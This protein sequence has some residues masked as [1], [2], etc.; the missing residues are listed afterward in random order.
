VSPSIGIAVFPRDGITA[1]TLIKN[2]DAAMY[3]AKE[4]GRSN[5]QFFNEKLSEAAFQAL[6]LETGLREAIRDAGFVLHYQPAVRVRDQSLTGVA[7][8]IRWPRHDGTLAS[9]DEFNPVAE[10]RGLII[11]IGMWVLNEACRQNKAWQDAGLPRVP[12]GINLSALQFRQKSLVAEVAR[13]LAESGLEPKYLEIE[14]TESM[15][16]DD[17][18]AMT[19]TLEGLKAL[20]VKL[21]I[22]DFGTGHS[23][24]VHLKRFPLDKLKIDRDFVRDIPEDPDDVAITSAIID[25]ARNMGITVLA[26]G[27]EKPEQLA[28][29]LARGCDEMQGFL[30]C[31]ALPARQ[32]EVQL[33]RLGKT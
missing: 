32:A 17:S 25:L 31:P 22:D 26:E 10:Q 8:L 12:V 1:D 15:L 6:T 5:F 33:Q 29:L 2:A 21:A 23:S 19:H 24:L 11:P 16:M 4:R 27:V 30:V 13:V 7:A 9:P 18:G 20:G 14:L 28:F 3:L